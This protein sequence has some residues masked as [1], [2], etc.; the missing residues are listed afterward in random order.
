M[1]AC[2]NWPS[3]LAEWGRVA[4]IKYDKEKKWLKDRGYNSW[5]EFH[6]A[7]KEPTK[8]I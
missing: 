7:N 2:E 4:Q 3:N 1:E 6:E 8:E 5:A